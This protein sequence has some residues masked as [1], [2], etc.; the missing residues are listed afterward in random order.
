MSASEVMPDADGVS[1]RDFLRAGSL[2]VVGLTG[3]ARAAALTGGTSRRAIFI[4][5]TGGASQLETFDPKP[6]APA[7]IR[8]PFKSIETSIPG[9]RFG[10]SLPGLA[11][12]ADQLCV[13]RSLNHD[14]API[15]ETG[16]QLLQTGQ[17]S[18]GP[19]QFPNWSSVVAQNVDARNG[20]PVSVVLPQPLFDTGVSTYRGQ[21]AGVLGTDWNPLTI[22]AEPDEE[23]E[24]I[25][26]LYGHSSFG[27]KLLQAR[28]LVERG[29]RCVTVNLF[30]SLRNQMTWDCHGDRNCGPATLFDYQDR[31]CPEFDRALSGLLD[32]LGQRGLLDDTLVVVTGEFGRTPHVNENMGRDHWPSCWSAV[33]AGGKVPGGLVIGASDA[34]AREPIERPVVPGE[35]TSTLLNW[36][37]VDTSQTVE[38]DGKS[39]PLITDAPLSELLGSSTRQPAL[40]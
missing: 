1:R 18:F 15:H 19:A 14:A 3:A 12:R 9:V 11:R 25:Q 40:V 16:M 37:G 27:R 21:S 31:L 10:E 26:R 36:F 2:T 5:M 13:I 8:G 20:A 30:D 22:S 7:S 34:M 28:Q 39:I 4:L 23:P 33:V 35:L 24:S 6:E 29:T 32:D 17:L 38:I